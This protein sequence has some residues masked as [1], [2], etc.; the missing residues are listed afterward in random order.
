MAVGNLGSNGTMAPETIEGKP[1]GLQADMFAVGVILYQMI[2]SY[3][4]FDSSDK[5]TF[6]TAVKENSI[7]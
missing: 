6:L 1:Y 2:F 3:Y 5:K 4:P 7:F